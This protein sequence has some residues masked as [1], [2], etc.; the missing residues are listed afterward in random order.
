MPYV[1]QES[2]EPRLGY[3]ECFTA[4]DAL[5]LNHPQLITPLLVLAYD[6]GLAAQCRIHRVNRA[7]PDQ[8][9]VGLVRGR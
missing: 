3:I 8:R 5:K 6:P 9:E 2:D 1:A 7:V 4:F